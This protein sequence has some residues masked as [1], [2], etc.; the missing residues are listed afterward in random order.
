MKHAIL[1][2]AILTLVFSKN[3]SQ[4]V[5]DYRSIASGTWAVA[6]TWQTWNGTAWVA[7][8]A[9]PTSANGVITIQSPHT[10][11][12]GAAVTVDQVIIN[13]G[14]TVRW[15]TGVL[16]IAN[17][18]G[19]DLIVNGTFIDESTS[20]AI[21]TASLARWQLGANGTYIKRR[22]GSATVWRD[23]YE[24]GMITIPAT[25]NWIIQKNSASNPILTTVGGTYYGNLTIENTFGGAWVTT[26]GSTFQGATDYPRIKGNFD[27]GGAGPGTVTFLNQH[28]NVAS[29]TLVQGN[30][31]V[32]AGNTFQNFGTGLALEGNLINNGTISYDLDDPRFIFFVGGNA[33]T[34]T[35][36]G[37]L[38]IYNM[39]MLKTANTLTLNSPITVDN[40]VDFT[41]GIIN[42]SA[43]N[44]L[45]LNSAATVTNANDLSF[46][47]GPVRRLGSTGITF[48]VGKVASY[49]PIGIGNGTGA[50]PINI[51]TEDFNSGGAGWTLN[52]VM[53][54]E[55]ADANFF[56]IS[57]NEGGTQSTFTPATA[58]IVPNLG[59]PT[60]CGLVNAANPTLHITSV[61]NP[62][63]G[64]AYDAGGLCGLLFCPQSNRQTTSPIINTTGFAGLE[65]VFDYIE[66]GQTTLD[67]GSVFYS[68]N[69]G[70]TWNLLDDMP[71]TATG[72]GG[73]GVW[74]T[75]ILPLPA[76]C[77]NITTLRIAFRWVNNDDGAGTDPSMAID[78]VIVRQAAPVNIFTAEYFPSNPQIPYGNVLA[79][80]LSAL[81]DCE[82]WILDRNS[83]TEARTV[84]LSWNAATC[85]NTLHPS[86]QVARYDGISTWQD[87]D[88]ISVGVPAGGTV[89][90]PA[91]VANF[92]PMAIAY[93]PTPLP[94]EMVNME[95]AC[96]EN[97]AV[98]TWQTVSEINN[99]HFEIEKSLDAVHWESEG[100]IEGHGNTNTLQSYSFTD[101]DPLEESYY[102]IKQVDYNGVFEIFDPLYLTCTYSNRGFTVYPNP[103]NGLIHLRIDPASTVHNI[104]VVNSLGKVV[105]QTNGSDITD[106]GIISIDL[107]IMPSGTYYIRA[108]MNEEWITE[109]VIVIK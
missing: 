50:L 89:T 55:G 9:A 87:H 75:R 13:T 100:R 17:G 35:N 96:I 16:T 106:T 42:S 71:K 29:G 56:V 57:G 109:P 20:N 91:P 63:G 101:Q 44:L 24:G 99:S 25:S 26:A 58:G 38:G 15:T 68:T 61:F 34:I 77:D 86:F 39:W 27:V 83:G 2:L 98:L 79:P 59:A 21:F 72:C 103:T 102:R 28:T 93:V 30:M 76:T 85:Y 52:Q 92:S 82:Y 23:N 10:V 67:N 36:T 81:S 14:G 95:V 3:F 90:T 74:V 33:Q 69:S 62:A 45:I 49:R 53:G 11:N 107:S 94:V 66:N 6:A 8:G 22:T 97:K 19:T 48:P 46:V 54:A 4:A 41:T 64:A 12:I 18:A 51:F 84:T 7:A 5:G 31:I 78:N 73:Q 47:N 1:T 105:Y 37:T 108:L 80:T 32:R 60:S 43:V 70:T 65:L 88:G 40:L 104:E